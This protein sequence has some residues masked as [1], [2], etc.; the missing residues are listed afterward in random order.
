MIIKTA[1]SLKA[2]KEAVLEKGEAVANA[3]K[4]KKA[5]EHMSKIKLQETKTGV[6]EAKLLDKLKNLVG[7]KEGREALKPAAKAYGATAAAVTGAAVL[8]KRK[9]KQ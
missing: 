7:T 2:V 9:K 4:G 1:I 8:A 5:F 3:F 6:R